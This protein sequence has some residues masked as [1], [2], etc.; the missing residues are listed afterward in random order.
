MLEKS[1]LPVWVFAIK[2]MKYR[3]YDPCKII[4]PLSWFH[5]ALK[6]SLSIKIE[7]IS[8]SKLCLFAVFTLLWSETILKGL[9]LN[10]YALITVYSKLSIIRPNRPRLLEFE[11]KDS[12]GRLIEIFFQI[13]RPGCLIEPKNWPLQSWN[14]TVWSNFSVLDL[15]E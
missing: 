15:V 3:F 12:T 5:K 6:T 2:V 14:K 9:I 7:H 4:L 1:N 10:H 11:K 13:S 8:C